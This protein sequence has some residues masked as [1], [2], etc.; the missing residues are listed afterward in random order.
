M[1]NVV[2]LRE[3]S[4]AA[5]PV[6]T[7][8]HT[9]RFPFV[10]D[11]TETQGSGVEWTIKNLLI[12]GGLG[13]VYGPPKSA[14]SFFAADAA[15]HVAHGLDFFGYKT[16]A[17]L[18]VYLCGEGAT[19]F[20]RRMHAWK[21]ANGLPATRNFCMLPQAI[22]LNA[23]NES[24]ASLIADLKSLCA[25]L[26]QPIVMIVIDTLARY[27]GQG[28][29]NSAPDMSRFIAS[30]DR[31][32]MALEQATGHRPTAL[33]VHHTGKNLSAGMR[34]SNALLGAA[35]VTIEVTSNDDG[36]RQARIADIK[37]ADKADPMFFR[38]ASQRLGIDEDGEPYYSCAVEPTTMAEGITIEETVDLPFGPNAPASKRG[39]G[40]AKKAS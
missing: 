38:L 30:I 31:I 2:P 20:K 16:K 23:D 34:G 24:I 37:D 35:D 5:Q 22:D 9:F 39:R 15:Y 27:F 10:F 28:D 17:G 11:G 40:R 18:V 21:L 1:N 36:I 3:N 8:N 19:G 12:S 25:A 29:E 14:K 13:V 4:D 33:I 32:Q 6:V 7:S 26:G